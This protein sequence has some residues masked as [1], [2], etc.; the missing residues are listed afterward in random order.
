MG[1]SNKNIDKCQCQVYCDTVTLYN[2]T[3]EYAIYFLLFP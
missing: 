1:Q 3:E 2:N